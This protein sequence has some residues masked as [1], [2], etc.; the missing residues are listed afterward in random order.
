MPSA[1]ILRKI[2]MCSDNGI[3]VG[4]IHLLGEKIRGDVMIV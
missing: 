1:M 3:R 4:V 2:P